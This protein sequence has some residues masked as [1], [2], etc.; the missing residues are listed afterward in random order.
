MKKNG[1]ATA[2]SGAADEGVGGVLAE[3]GGEV[4]VGGE[5]GGDADDG[6][7]NH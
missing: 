3:G 1:K 4:V 6:E 5:E 7:G 2:K